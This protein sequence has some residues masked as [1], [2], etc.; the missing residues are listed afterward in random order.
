MWH[1]LAGS[2]ISKGK[3]YLLCQVYFCFV[4]DMLSVCH[5]EA[6]Y[7]A[8]IKI[9]ELT[10]PFLLFPCGI[11]LLSSVFL[12]L[13]HATHTVP[14]KQ[15]IKSIQ[16]QKSHIAIWQH[17]FIPSNT[18]FCV[19]TQAHVGSCFSLGHPGQLGH[20]WSFWWTRLGF[21]LENWVP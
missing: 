3:G 19:N 4:T 20:I 15:E 8:A 17:G 13:R 9:R 1:F 7:K 21:P 12:L 11:I 16:K 10:Y 5:G 2:L 14:A 6:S 18:Y